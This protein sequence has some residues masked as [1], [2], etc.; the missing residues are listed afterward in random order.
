ML[1]TI[2]RK[3]IEDLSWLAGILDG[4]GS[5]Y[6]SVNNSLSDTNSLNTQVNFSNTD[7]RVIAKVTRVLHQNGVKFLYNVNS[8][9][10]EHTIVTVVVKRRK[11]TAQVLNILAPFMSSKKLQATHMMDA[12]RYLHLSKSCLDSK[13]F[14]IYE[15]FSA[16]KNWYVDP[17]NISRK[18]N[19]SLNFGRKDPCGA[20]D[21][22]SYL[23]GILDGEGYITAVTKETK[24][25]LY[26][27][28]I[29]EIVN[30]DIK[31]IKRVSEIYE[32]AGLKFHY[33]Y[34]RKSK[35]NPKHKNSL[36]LRITT[37]GSA[38]KILNETMPYLTAKKKIAEDVVSVL[39]FIADFRK[40]DQKG[41]YTEHPTFIAKMKS[42]ED[43]GYFYFDSQRLI[44][45]ADTPLVLD[46]RVHAA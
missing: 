31:L 13:F 35:Y 40:Y 22:I 19:K 44:C 23:A 1:E 25:K 12:L 10:R 24:G 29:I 34:G 14:Q 39:N 6:M 9:D 17:I 42:L 7:M 2:S 3:E 46:D 33:T 28:P 20:Y 8:R 21:D 38:K 37:Q 36:Y 5:I 4:E 26:C 32:R 11:N 16:E 27:F 18:A 15:R 30:T 41:L 43:K 45:A